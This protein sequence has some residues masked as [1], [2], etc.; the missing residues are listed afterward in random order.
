MMRILIFMASISLV[1][2][3]QDY[4]N[5]FNKQRLKEN[6]LEFCTGIYGYL[7]DGDHLIEPRIF[8]E[9]IKFNLFVE[10]KLQRKI[11]KMRQ[12]E[13]QRKLIGQKLILNKL[14]AHFLDRHF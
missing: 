12:K 7:C 4:I 11:K 10:D 3:Y 14:R 6:S 5:A 2:S 13:R 9:S 8:G 1:I